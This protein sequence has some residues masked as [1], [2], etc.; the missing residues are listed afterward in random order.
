MMWLARVLHKQ[1]SGGTLEGQKTCPGALLVL[2]PREE[3]Q[4]ED[5]KHGGFLKKDALLPINCLNQMLI[6]LTSLEPVTNDN[7]L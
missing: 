2:S 7:A 5:R 1:F 4:L 6:L 3:R